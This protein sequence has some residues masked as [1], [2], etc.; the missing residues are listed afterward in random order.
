LENRNQLQSR[1]EI[2]QEWIGRS[3]FSIVGIVK[4]FCKIRNTLGAL[5]GNQR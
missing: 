5:S 1:W 4:T 3:R 2:L